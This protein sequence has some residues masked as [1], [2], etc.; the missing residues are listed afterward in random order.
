MLTQVDPC[1]GHNIVACISHTQQ[2]EEEEENCGQPANQ[3]LGP[4]FPP[5]IKITVIFDYVISD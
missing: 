3:D 5:L 2:M 1:N 4:V